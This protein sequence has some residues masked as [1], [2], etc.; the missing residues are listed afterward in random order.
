M[1]L[2]QVNESFLYKLIVSD[3]E[4]K[5]V[6]YAE[7]NRF[8][9]IV[10]QIVKIYLNVCKRI[11][12]TLYWLFAPNMLLKLA[13]RHILL[14]SIMFAIPPIIRLTIKPFWRF[15]RYRVI[16]RIVMGGEWVS[17]Y[18]EIKRQCSDRNLTY[19]EYA[20][21]GSKLDEMEGYDAWRISKA[22]KLYSHNR[23]QQDLIELAKIRRKC[24]GRA[25][26]TH[27]I[28]TRHH[29]MRDL[30]EFLRSRIERNYCGIANAEL[31]SVTTVGTKKLIE[32]FIDNICQSLH[33]IANSEDKSISLE[34]KIVY[35]QELR[36]VLGRT[37]LCLSGG[38][39][40]G[41]Y[42][43]GVVLSMAENNLLPKIITGASAGSV[44]AAFAC[45]RLEH[46]LPR[47]TDDDILN[48]KIY[49]EK[50][51]RS[52]ATV[53]SV[54]FKRF[55]ET[56]YFLDV[57]VL[58]DYVKDNIGDMT[59]LEA[60]HKTGKIL[61]IAVSGSDSNTMPRLLNFLTAPH[62]VI[63]SAVVASCA[64]PVMFE[65]QELYIKSPTT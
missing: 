53:L 23:I 19:K 18:S 32:D 62:V 3:I 8:F 60:Y 33:Y 35:F 2:T 61:N 16:L 54:R 38:G 14:F 17:K 29:P 30:M 43:W 15:L 20:A 51:R 48:L 9:R 46:E 5:T 34:E 13:M 24:D 55:W 50:E 42:H 7:S 22:S 10:S 44:I 27:L 6:E 56:G 31:Y 40:L 25:S 64:I 21:Y 57:K 45:T 39:A 52:W 47:L 63:Y 11:M 26:M 37:A 28:D 59:F 1:S 49:H 65:P 4:K 12:G 36:H 58:R 41:Y